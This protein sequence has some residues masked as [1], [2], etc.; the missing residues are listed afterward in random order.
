M[1]AGA[2]VLLGAESVMSNPLPIESTPTWREALV[3]AAVFAVVAIG[4]EVPFRASGFVAD[5]QDHF[6]RIA[7]L[8]RGVIGW[9]EYLL[10]PHFVHVLPAWKLWYYVEWKVFG[11]DSAA[12]HLAIACVQALGALG[13]YVFLATLLRDKFAALCGGLLWAGCAMGWP[14]NPLSWIA[15]SH[16]AFGSSGWL[17]ALACLALA[18]ARQSRAW[19]IAAGG[20]A[21]VSVLCMTAM[22]VLVPALAIV[23][24]WI[25][26]RRDDPWW[27]TVGVALALAPA[28]VT[29]LGLQAWSYSQ[30]QYEL[31]HSDQI[32][33]STSAYAALMHFPLALGNLLGWVGFPDADAGLVYKSTLAACLLLGAFALP[34]PRETKKLY[35]V[36]IVATAAWCWLGNFKSSYNPAERLASWSRYS[37]LP[38]LAWCMMF[39][40]SIAAAT[41]GLSLKGRGRLRNAMVAALL[42]FFFLQMNVAASSFRVWELTAQLGKYRELERGWREALAALAEEGDRGGAPAV[43]P[44]GLIEFPLRNYRL[45]TIV[46]VLNPDCAAAVFVKDAVEVTEPERQ[47]TLE[48]IRRRLPDQPQAQGLLELLGAR[49]AESNEK[50]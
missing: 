37:Y 11:P 27:L 33:L 12:F 43:L 1:S 36:A 21:L 28:F 46:T 35:V 23:S 19:L 8:E 41:S 15:A 10:N 42:L 49:S 18:H 20:C 32:D 17:A 24:W 44:D 48:L 9:R 30:G 26:R 29:G 50:G 25:L 45:S 5:D 40:G 2:Q 13:L 38:A 16:L 47:R 22:F 39:A 4:I 14:D 34:A 6:E 31:Q 7:D 3:L